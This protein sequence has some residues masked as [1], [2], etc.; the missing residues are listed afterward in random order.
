LTRKEKRMEKVKNI[1]KQL[2][3]WCKRHSFSIVLVI[4]LCF[5]INWP[6]SPN[7][8]LAW[9]VWKYIV[10][11]GSEG[12]E[13]D[14][15]VQSQLQMH[16]TT[17]IAVN[18]IVKKYVMLGMHYTQVQSIMEANN[19]NCIYYPY[20]KNTKVENHILNCSMP[21]PIRW[22]KIPD[23]GLVLDRVNSSFT[24]DTKTHRVINISSSVD[25][26]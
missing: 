12:E 9:E 20:E 8:K 16:D 23:L 1:F 17:D 15:A 7:Q 10:T 6:P 13:L 11:Y 2:F 26:N 19:Y 14:K 5:I 18:N 21:N 3:G 22:M 24:L 25:L 4:G